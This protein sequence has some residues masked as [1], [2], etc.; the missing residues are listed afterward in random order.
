MRFNLWINSDDWFYENL[1]LLNLT[2]VNKIDK[3]AGGLL[4]VAHGNLKGVLR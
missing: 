2:I 1:V 3:L 4:I